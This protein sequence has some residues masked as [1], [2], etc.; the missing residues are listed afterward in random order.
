M[1][2]IDAYDESNEIVKAELFTKGM[3]RLPETAIVVFKTEIIDYI[4]NNENFIDYSYTDVAGEKVRLYKTSYNGKDAIVY[5]TQ[6]GGPATTSMMEELI[7]RGVKKFIIFG[8]CGQLSSNVPKGAFIIPTEAYRDE[9]TS[10]HYMPTSDFVKVSTA[11][12]LSKIFD[13][14]NIHYF[15]TKTWTTDALYRETEEK[16]NKMRELG[17]D[18]VEM[19]CASIM[20]M[21]EFRE[22]KSYQFLYCDDTLENTE[23]D[24]RTIHDDRSPLLIKCLDIALKI[25]DETK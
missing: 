21:S 3:D 22:I 13:E 17:C 7:S 14:N 1:S 9:G 10:Y 20:A 4:K 23:W 16:V 12:E 18:V 5:R 2:I 19:E 8:S 11:D 25:N 24:L 6:V 15:K